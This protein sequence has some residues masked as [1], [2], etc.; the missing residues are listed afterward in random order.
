MERLTMSVSPGE[1]VDRIIIE[2]LRAFNGSYEGAK[3]LAALLSV[4][5]Q[6]WHLE[7]EAFS[8]DTAGEIR[9]LSRTRA[10]LKKQIDETLG[11]EPER[12]S[13]GWQD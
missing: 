2:M 7:E 6:I 9:K 5:H 1:M 3:D 4:N 11:C 13:D 8:K 10:R 12:K